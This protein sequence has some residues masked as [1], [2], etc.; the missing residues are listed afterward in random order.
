MDKQC[1]FA[2]GQ[3]YA[4]VPSKQQEFG[5]GTQVGVDA[6]TLCTTGR[7]RR[8]SCFIEYDEGR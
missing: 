1:S 6:V 3:H 4:Q 5:N 2:G 7:K 8:Q